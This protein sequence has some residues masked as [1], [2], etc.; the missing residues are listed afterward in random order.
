[1]TTLSLRSIT[2]SARLAFM[3]LAVSA[4]FASC[5]SV[6]TG[7]GVYLV[8]VTDLAD[9]KPVDG[10]SLT[11]TGAGTRA[12]GTPP[13]LATTDEDG[14]ATLA[15]GGWGAVD[16]LVTNNGTANNG[17]TERWLV[18]QG[19]IAVNGGVS[20]IDPMR[21]IVGAGPQGG[22]SIYRMSITRVEKGAKRD[23]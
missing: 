19:R 13:S 3:T 5:H 17:I 10:L 2:R 18:N 1:M 4:G 16:L 14:Q 8:T 23:N 21:L 15:F 12:H 6:P 9:G 20:R 11:A 22:S 7:A